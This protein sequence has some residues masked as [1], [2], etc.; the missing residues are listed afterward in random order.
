MRACKALLEAPAGGGSSIGEDAGQ[1][2]AQGILAPRFEVE[3]VAAQKQTLQVLV[4]A[5]VQVFGKGEAVHHDTK[6]VEVRRCD[7]VKLC[8]SIAHAHRPG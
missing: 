3:H 5:T 2:G 7:E 8:T 1:I 6:E 4:L